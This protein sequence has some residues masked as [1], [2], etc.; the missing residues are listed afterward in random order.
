MFKPRNRTRRISRLNSPAQPPD[1]NGRVSLILCGLLALLC[2]QCTPEQRYRTLSFFFDGVPN[3]SATPVAATAELS[4]DEL[5]RPIAGPKIEPVSKHKPFA[6][7][8]CDDCHAGATEGTQITPDSRVLCARCH[9]TFGKSWTVWHG[10]AAAWACTE[11]HSGHESENKALLLQPVPQLCAKCHDLGAAS[12]LA[13]NEA[14]AGK[15]DCTRC[16]NPHGAVNNSL[17]NEQ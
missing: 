14:H 17:L 13:S 1:R 7:E 10:P 15:D 9:T 6:E 3:P 11:C 16:H 4:E 8:K 2:T 5:P 12:F